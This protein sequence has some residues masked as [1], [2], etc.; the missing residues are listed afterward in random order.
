VLNYIVY[1]VTCPDCLVYISLPPSLSPSLPSPS[2]SIYF[3]PISHIHTHSFFDYLNH[4]ILCICCQT[5][6]EICLLLHILFGT[7]ELLHV[8]LYRWQGYDRE[9]HDD[10]IWWYS[11]MIYIQSDDTVWWHI[12]IMHSSDIVWYQNEI[13]RDDRMH[14]NKMLIQSTNTL[15]WYSVLK[16]SSDTSD[17]WYSLIKFSNAA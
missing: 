2:L 3:H 16:Q 5:D 9:F 10:T 4:I 7:N 12:S 6:H 8:M 15:H 11:M 17:L 1:G 13:Q 14:W